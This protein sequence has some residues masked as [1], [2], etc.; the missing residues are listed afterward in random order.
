MRVVLFFACL[1]ICSTASA[2]DKLYDLRGPTRQV[3]DTIVSELSVATKD[4]DLFLN[5]IDGRVKLSISAEGEIREQNR[6]LELKGREI[7]KVET[8]IIKDR[9][10]TTALLFGFGEPEEEVDVLENTTLIGV[11]EDN[12]NWV[13]SLV[14]AEPTKEQAE[15]LKDRDG[16]EN[17][18]GWYP[19]EKVPAGHVWTTDA[20]K[21]KSVL[22]KI[23]ANVNGTVE[24]RFVKVET[25]NEEECAVIES[26][27]EISLS[28]RIDK[29]SDPEAIV[30]IDGKL[31]TWKSLKSGI[32]VKSDF[33]GKLHGK[34]TRPV[35]DE[36]M[37]VEITGDFE[38]KEN[39]CLETPTKGR[40]L[41]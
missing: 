11:K 21:M 35:D 41:D 1:F 28:I 22:G 8:K 5:S 32:S 9:F 25:V 14:D 15:A 13:F 3:G 39:S 24:H 34:A 33:T 36:S 20:A 23:V 37:A 4:T 38:G 7:I 31:T 29:D 19:E 27:G 10:T 26:E 16:P 6:I 30:E 2:Q 17:E 40:S 12:G 18:D